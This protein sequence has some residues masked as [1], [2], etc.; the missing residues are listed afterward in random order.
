MGI[1]LAEEK[2]DKRAFYKVSK[3]ENGISSF[4]LLSHYICIYVYPI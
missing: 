1:T 4:I 3:I 2:K